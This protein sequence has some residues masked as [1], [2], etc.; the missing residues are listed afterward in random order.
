MT[1]SDFVGLGLHLIDLTLVFGGRDG[2][3]EKA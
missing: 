2:V 1:M 3:D